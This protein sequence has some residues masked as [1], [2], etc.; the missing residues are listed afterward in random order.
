MDSRQLSAKPQLL[1]QH[2]HPPGW[3]RKHDSLTLSRLISRLPDNVLDVE[4]P[5]HMQN[6][7]LKHPVGCLLSCL[8]RYLINPDDGIYRHRS[9]TSLSAWQTDKSRLQT[10]TATQT[11][12]CGSRPSEVERSETS[13]LVGFRLEPSK[14]W[15][16]Y[17][18]TDG[19]GF[20]NRHPG[21]LSNLK[22][23]ISKLGRGQ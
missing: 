7:G 19:D 10:D 11:R 1:F 22:S 21:G 16:L 6:Q 8:T 5:L 9:F 18:L 15:L 2:S 13:E 23:G 17:S 12:I 14:F 3:R 20:H 4:I